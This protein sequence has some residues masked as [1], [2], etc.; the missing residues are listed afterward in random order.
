M[1]SSRWVSFLAAMCVLFASGAFYYSH[2]TDS[3]QLDEAALRVEQV[4]HVIGA[5]RGVDDPP[6]EASFAH[7]TMIFAGL[8]AVALVSSVL[9]IVSSLISRIHA[10][11]VTDH[12]H[13][14][15]QA[16]S[17]EVDHIH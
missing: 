5:W 8:A 12:M 2:A 1:T 17:V 7:I 9:M 3:E 15:L 14:L 10:Q 13:A 6:D 16:K 4:P 11:V